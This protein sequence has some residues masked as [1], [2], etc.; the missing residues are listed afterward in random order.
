M[1]ANQSSQ[2]TDVTNVVQNSVMNIVNK[3]QQTTSTDT[4]NAQS[5]NITIGS[6]TGCSYTTNQSI[7]SSG[8]TDAISTFN[9]KDKI[10]TM[11]KAAVSASVASEQSSVNGFLALAFNNQESNEDIQSN[12]NTTIDENVTDDN[13]QSLI[14]TAQNI[15]QGNFNIGSITCTPGQPGLTIDQTMV[16]KEYA[17]Q[18][19]G[20][21]S[22]VMMKNTAIATAVSKEASTQTSKNKGVASLISGLMLYLLIP[23]LLIGAVLFLPKIFKKIYEAL[24]SRACIS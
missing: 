10:A 4:T 23:I 8:V 15:Q 18:V 19:T 2:M 17:K 7:N 9:S 20:I 24:P 6:S 5:I 12:L 21:I 16:V 1:G 3:Q 14:A 11:M 13:V 22:E